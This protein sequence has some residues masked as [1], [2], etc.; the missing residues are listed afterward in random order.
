MFPAK[1]YDEAKSD[2]SRI[3]LSESNVRALASLT[4]DYGHKDGVA[5][6]K[7]VEGFEPSA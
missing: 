7:P 1:Q 5:D 4:T 2:R 6:L 3:G